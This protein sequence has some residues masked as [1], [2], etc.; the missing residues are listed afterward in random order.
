M[1]ITVIEALIN[2]LLSVAYL[3]GESSELQEAA[4]ETDVIGT[5]CSILDTLIDDKEL[6]QMNTGKDNTSQTVND[7]LP[8]EPSRKEVNSILDSCIATISNHLSIRVYYWLLLR[9]AH[10]MKNAGK[11]QVIMNDSRCILTWMIV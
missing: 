2:Q 8:K 5:L 11:R 4:C 9:S 7:V 10:L 1:C 3:V 6:P